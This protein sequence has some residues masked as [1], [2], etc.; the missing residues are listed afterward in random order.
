MFTSSDVAKPIPGE[1]M[2]H[3][4]RFRGTACHERE[5][6]SFEVAENIENHLLSFPLASVF[7]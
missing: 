7:G 5:I 4:L 6:L 3:S 1:D 2:K